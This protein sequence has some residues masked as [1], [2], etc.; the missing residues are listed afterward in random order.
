MISIVGAQVRCGGD[1]LSEKRF[2]ELSLAILIRNSKQSCF[3]GSVVQPTGVVQHRIET[4]PA[5]IDPGPRG[6]QHLMHDVMAPR[7][8][9]CTLCASEMKSGRR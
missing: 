4:E 3:T 8:P 1:Q 9:G 5:N 6:G 7:R 2:I